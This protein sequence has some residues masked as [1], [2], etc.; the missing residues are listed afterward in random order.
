M[1]LSPEDS[2]RFYRIWWPL[3]CYVNDQTNLVADLPIAPKT[4]SVNPQDAAKIRDA[5]WA[6]PDY[7]QGFV[8]DNPAAL[9]EED[10]ALAASWHHRVSGT[11]IIMRHLKKH[12]IFLLDSKQ[13]AAFGVLGII[14][15]IDE[16]LPFAPPVMVEAV[17]L[18]FE[19]KIIYDG[20]IM[21]YSVSF[22]GGIRKGFTQSLRT[23][24]ELG[25][26]VT[27]LEPRDGED[28]K[29]DAVIDGNRKILA[30]FRKDLAKAGLSEKMVNQ[31]SAVVE[32][33]VKTQLQKLHPVRSLLR[34]TE[35]DLRHYFSLPGNTA[36]RVSFKRLVKF[37]LNSER[38]D[39]DTAE[40]L[41]YFLKK[42]R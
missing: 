14:S 25:G 8:D 16:V 39:W 29:T 7:L 36:N 37:L 11:F 33:F 10:L 1:I 32:A 19:G 28:A 38:I 6:S 26:L 20:L 3:L 4:S 27:S 42:Q 23:A 18:P 40:D 12:S 2:A 15:P 30:E 5:L 31:H 41:E 35:E 9:A 21:P 24:T 13:P 22:G 17:L 34:L